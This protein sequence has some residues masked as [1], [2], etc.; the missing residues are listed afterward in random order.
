MKKT[1]LIAALAGIA[2]T[3]AF[4]GSCGGAEIVT[5]KEGVEKYIKDYYGNEHLVLS[6]TVYDNN[7]TLVWVVSD[8]A[9]LN[10][11]FAMTFANKPDNKY[12]FVGTETVNKVSNKIW[13]CFW[14]DG[15]SFYINDPDCDEFYFEDNGRSVTSKLGEMPTTLFCNISNI[16]DDVHVIF[17][18][19]NGRKVLGS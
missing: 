16:D 5:G 19:K 6:E 2:A 8:S 4:A 10:T 3:A 13:E 12:E 17:R 11:C 1:K 14:H 7:Q 15:V 18:D 9:M